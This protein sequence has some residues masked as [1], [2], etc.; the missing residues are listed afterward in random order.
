M[1][2]A[3]KGIDIIGWAGVGRPVKL[4]CKLIVA[5]NYALSGGIKAPSNQIVRR[6]PVLCGMVV[7]IVVAIVYGRE[8]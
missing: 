8:K 6:A 2:Q 5:G 7:V 3:L 1:L 4:L